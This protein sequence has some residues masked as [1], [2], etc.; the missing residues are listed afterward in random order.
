MIATAV[1][2]SQ[3]RFIST[4][5]LGFDK[6]QL[7]V[8]PLR[9]ELLRSKHEAIKAELLNHPNITHVSASANMPGGSDY[10]VPIVPEGLP[11]GE[12]YSIRHLIAD[13]DFVKTFGMEIVAG[14]D[15]S[16]DFPSDESRG[17]TVAGERPR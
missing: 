4:K 8:V 14:R 10:G 9:T 1:V 12:T 6:E 11:P 16:T 15:L 2:F 13:H 7:I 5:S 17:V 3:R